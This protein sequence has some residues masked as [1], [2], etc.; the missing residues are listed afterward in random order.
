MDR[1]PTRQRENIGHKFIYHFCK[2]LLNSFAALPPSF[3]VYCCISEKEDRLLYETVWCAQI[4]EMLSRQCIP[5]WS[6][7]A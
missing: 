5:K 2:F 6:K 7:T 1:E 4:K 3:T